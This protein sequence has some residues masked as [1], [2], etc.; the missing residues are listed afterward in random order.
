MPLWTVPMT[1]ES[2]PHPEWRHSSP[3]TA[4]E[5][6]ASVLPP[7][8]PELLPPEHAVLTLLIQ[9]LLVLLGPPMDSV[10]TPSTLL[11][12]EDRTAPPP[13]DF[14]DGFATLLDMHIISVAFLTNFKRHHNG[15]TTINIIRQR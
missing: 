10:P 4:K 13:A 7:P 11:L 12:K 6:V 2:A 9:A 14:V 5:H 1:L 3:P 8:L 15:L